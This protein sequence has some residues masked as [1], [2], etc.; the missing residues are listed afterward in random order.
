ML[1]NF[2]NSGISYAFCERHIVVMPAH[3]HRLLMLVKCCET[4][5]CV[6]QRLWILAQ[7]V[8]SDRNEVITKLCTCKVLVKAICE[9]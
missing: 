1:P 7:L 6:K 9:L 5:L 3:M 2:K 4:N 8:N